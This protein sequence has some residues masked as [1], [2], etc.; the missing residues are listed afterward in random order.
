LLPEL[1]EVEPKVEILN[2]DIEPKDVNANNCEDQT[3][4]NIT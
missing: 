4:K 1:K 2:E 3:N